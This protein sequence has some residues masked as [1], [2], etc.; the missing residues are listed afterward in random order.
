M[1]SGDQI[2]PI[3]TSNV[4]VHP[5]EPNA[6]PLKDWMDSH[7]QFLSTPADTL[8]LPAHNLPF[9]GVRERLRGL[10]SHH[11]DR[12]LAIEETC[13]EPQIA[14]DLLPVL[15]ARELDPRQMMMAL[16]EAIAHLHL[17]MHR[18]RIE[19]RLAED[20]VYRFL[21]ID[22]DLSRR[23]HPDAHDAPSDGPVMV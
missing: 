4:S 10:I 13:V 2:L 22:P 17:L 16:G 15:F 3:I 8:V 18:N 20:G 12:M 11:D 23:A 21:S 5:T 19:R 7:D 9:Y 1:I 6:N 14:K